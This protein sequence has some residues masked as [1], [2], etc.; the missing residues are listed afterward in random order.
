[1]PDPSP[2]LADRIRARASFLTNEASGARMIGRHGIAED[3]IFTAAKLTASACALDML[4]MVMGAD[5]I[6]ERKEP[7]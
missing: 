3:M 4:D 2:S 6:A 7:K 1:M 5:E